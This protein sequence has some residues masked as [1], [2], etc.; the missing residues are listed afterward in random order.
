MSCHR[1]PTVAFL[2]AALTALPALAQQ[3]PRP[4]RDII[5]TPRD[6]EREIPRERDD[7]W[8]RIVPRPGP[9]E[10][11]PLA[12]PPGSVNPPPGGADFCVG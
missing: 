11:T 3:P 9:V 10:T 6:P 5:E 7:P 12:P 2:L 4:P 1:T 8:G